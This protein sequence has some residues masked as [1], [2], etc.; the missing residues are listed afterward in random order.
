MTEN[1]GWRIGAGEY[2]TLGLVQV[3]S[4]YKLQLAYIG[5]K[6]AT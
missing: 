5:A 6:G 4:E 1:A 2:G 3:V